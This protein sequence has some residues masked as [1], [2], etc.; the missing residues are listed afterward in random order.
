MQRNALFAALFILLSF[1]V[2]AQDKPIEQ[3]WMECAYSHY[4]DGGKALKQAFTN[5]EQLLIKSELLDDSSPKAYK[6]MLLKLQ[7]TTF[8]DDK[9]IPDFLQVFSGLDSLEVENSLVKQC[10]QAIEA[11]EAFTEEVQPILKA[12]DEIVVQNDGVPKSFTDMIPEKKLNLNFYKMMVFVSLEMYQEAQYYESESYYT[13]P[14]ELEPSTEFRTVELNPE[15]LPSYDWGFSNT[16]S[17]N[18]RGKISMLNEEVSL[19]YVEDY[20]ISSG[21]YTSGMSPSALILYEGYDQRVYNNLKTSI[22]G[23]YLQ[24]WENIAQAEYNMN[25]SRLSDKQK[26]KITKRFPGVLYIVKDFE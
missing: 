18:E 8:L 4:R 25:Y 11:G 26:L 23:A 5:Y 2:T 7:D 24:I 12:M 9:E 3:Q 1:T 10:I 21:E 20:Y 13:E 22:Q 17:L 14:P 15:D 6:Q 19:E 16:I